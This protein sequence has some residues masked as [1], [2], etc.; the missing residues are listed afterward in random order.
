[1]YVPKVG[2]YSYEKEKDVFEQNV[3]G[4]NDFLRLLTT[5][6]KYQD[7]MNPVEDQDFIAQLAQFTALE[8]T[9]N[10]VQTM[11]DF[12]KGQEQMGQVGQASSLLGK[13]VVVINSD[14]EEL[15]TG[16]VSSVQF[17]DGV[18]R[19]VVDGEIFFLWEVHEVKA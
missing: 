18:P 11:E 16:K 9:Q 4:K 12:V 19:L 14:T 3:L 15:F 13:E 2:T 8:Q 10:L 7:P 5:Q 1:M 6:L 17:V